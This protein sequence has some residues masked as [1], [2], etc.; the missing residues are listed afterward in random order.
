MS[1]VNEPRCRATVTSTDNTTHT[2]NQC[3]ITVNFCQLAACLGHLNLLIFVV[4]AYCFHS[5]PTQRFAP[6][7]LARNEIRGSRERE[8]A[9]GY[10]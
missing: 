9:L 10:L 2:V 3:V 7:G 1:G 4:R 8:Y 5:C 6:L